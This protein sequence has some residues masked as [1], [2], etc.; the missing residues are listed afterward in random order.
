MVTSAARSSDGRYRR[1][2]SQRETPATARLVSRPVT[3]STV[4]PASTMRCSGGW[5]SFQT[6]HVRMIRSMVPS[7][8]AAFSK[9]SH[10][11]RSAAFPADN[12]PT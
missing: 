2:A 6:C 3:G 9:R 5:S 12:T 7:C 1:A 10:R 4:S 8:M 11:S